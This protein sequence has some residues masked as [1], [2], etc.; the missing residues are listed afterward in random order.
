MLREYN[1][2]FIFLDII[3]YYWVIVLLIWW[4]GERILFY[5]LFFKDLVDNVNWVKYVIFEFEISYVKELE[6]IVC[7]KF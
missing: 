7:L 6:V 5:F 4:E 3:R 2:I 1:G